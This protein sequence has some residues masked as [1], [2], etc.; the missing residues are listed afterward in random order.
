[1]EQKKKGLNGLISNKYV[2]N[3]V[4]HLSLCNFMFKLIVLM[5]S[6]ISDSRTLLCLYLG[7]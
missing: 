7:I 3:N 6:M 2:A 1:M 4:E 5:L